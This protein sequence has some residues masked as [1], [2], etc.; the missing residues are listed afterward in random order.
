MGRF[1]VSSSGCLPALQRKL[2]QRGGRASA[3][4]L[5]KVGRAGATN[6]SPSGLGAQLDRK[7][8]REMGKDVAH[9][10][11]AR[12][13]GQEATSVQ[14]LPEAPPSRRAAP[15]A[16]A[17][18]ARPAPLA[19]GPPGNSVSVLGL[20]LR[21]RWRGGRASGTPPAATRR[22][23]ARADRRGMSGLTRA[24]ERWPQDPSAPGRRPPGMS[25]HQLRHC[26]STS[27]RAGCG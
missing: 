24:A 10:T 19:L 4:L 14:S 3:A 8:E 11:Q 13:W 20:S 7:I 23:G 16:D 5:G 15:T 27:L 2:R 21:V 1:Q 26:C 12:L 9:Q 18:R 25:S 6:P 22:N 17:E